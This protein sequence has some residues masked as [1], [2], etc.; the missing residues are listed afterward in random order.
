MADNI[1]ICNTKRLKTV[2]TVTEWD[3]SWCLCVISRSVTDGGGITL[4]LLQIETKAGPVPVILAE[5]GFPDIRGWMI[6]HFGLEATPKVGDYPSSILPG[7]S[8][9]LSGKPDPDPYIGANE[10]LS[11]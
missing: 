10:S 6:S 3:V 5:R 8:D 11:K 9:L 2:L 7:K 1:S 4:L